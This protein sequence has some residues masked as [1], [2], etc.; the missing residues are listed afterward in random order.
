MSYDI[1][2]RPNHQ[3]YLR[4]L[5][6]MTPW[7]RMQQAFRL[8]ERSRKLFRIGL[9]DRFPD[10]SDDELHQLYLRLLDRCHNRNY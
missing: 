7:E 2:P 6:G 9:K 8:T 4:V 1:K 5:A 3:Q 10:L